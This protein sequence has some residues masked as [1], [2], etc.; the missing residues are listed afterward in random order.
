MLAG[1][2]TDTQLKSQR[3]NPVQHELPPRPSVL[4]PSFPSHTFLTLSAST[5]QSQGSTKKQQLQEG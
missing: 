4:T 1:L 5:F 2:V 3:A